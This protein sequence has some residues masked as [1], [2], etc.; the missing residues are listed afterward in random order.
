MKTRSSEDEIDVSTCRNVVWLGKVVIC[1]AVTSYHITVI[2]VV[3]VAEA[4]AFILFVLC[5][6]V[7]RKHV[8]FIICRM[9]Q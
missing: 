3:A 6:C 4:D 9:F 7:F 2:M 8:N 5:L 1:H